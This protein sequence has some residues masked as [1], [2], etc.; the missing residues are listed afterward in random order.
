[1]HARDDTMTLHNF[2]FFLLPHNVQDI[3]EFDVVFF[4]PDLLFRKCEQGQ[5]WGL[6]QPSFYLDVLSLRWCR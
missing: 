2:F 5:K 3:A 6:G 4:A 1:M